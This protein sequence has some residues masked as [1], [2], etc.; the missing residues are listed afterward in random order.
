M[1]QRHVH[2]QVDGRERA[3][4]ERTSRC[5]NRGASAGT[6]AMTMSSSARPASR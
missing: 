5:Q 4:R 1:E 3:D 6:A 2:R